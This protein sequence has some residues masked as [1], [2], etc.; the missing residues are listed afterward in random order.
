MEFGE[1]L[2]TLRKAKGI[3]QEELAERLGVSRQAVSKWEQGMG[4]PEMETMLALSKTL[5][6][7]LDFLVSGEAT[8]SQT[9]PQEPQRNTPTGKV[10]IRSQNGRSL[11][12]CIK[13]FS[14]PVVGGIIKSR[15]DEPQCALFGVDATSFWCENRTLLGWYVDKESIEKELKEIEKALKNGE[16][17][18]ELQFAAKVKSKFL[19]VKLDEE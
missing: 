2:R 15:V 19:C 1:N 7:S 11:V 10:M 14:Y 4:Y 18:Y 13:V 3:S 12:N 16:P 5:E 9:Q 6:V 17:F 8:F